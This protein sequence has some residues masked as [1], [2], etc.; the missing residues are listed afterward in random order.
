MKS[1][2]FSIFLDF[3]LDDATASNEQIAQEMMVE[4][5]SGVPDEDTWTLNSRLD[6]DHFQAHNRQ[7]H[8][9]RGLAV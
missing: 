7:R 2:H 5:L 9:P 1:R 4:G 8:Y 6:D 3:R